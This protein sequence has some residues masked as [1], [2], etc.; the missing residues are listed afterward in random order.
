MMRTLEKVSLWAFGCFSLVIVAGCDEWQVDMFVGESTA[1]AAVHKYVAGVDSKSL[2][3]ARPMRARDWGSFH[4]KAV[5]SP[6]EGAREAQKLERSGTLNGH[7]FIIGH[8]GFP[9]WIGLIP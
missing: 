2:W 8:G 9:D 5:G 3:G 7:H 6:D 4:N 1:P